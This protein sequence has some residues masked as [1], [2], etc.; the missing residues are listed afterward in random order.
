MGWGTHLGDPKRD[1]V[2][3]GVWVLTDV[4]GSSVMMLI[5]PGPPEWTS[6]RFSLLC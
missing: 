3:S 4:R 6:D 1:S 2:E 5:S